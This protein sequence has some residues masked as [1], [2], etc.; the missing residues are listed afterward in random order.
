MGIKKVDQ[1][2]SNNII[3]PSLDIKEH[4]LIDLFKAKNVGW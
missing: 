4:K 2:E 3:S 1:S